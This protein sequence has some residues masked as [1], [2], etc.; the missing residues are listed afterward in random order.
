MERAFYRG[1]SHFFHC[2]FEGA[3]V[4]VGIFIHTRPKRQFARKPL[5]ELDG[6]Y[7]GS[8]VWQYFVKKHTRFQEI[9]GKKAL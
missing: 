3:Y 5:R 7:H 8:V 9:I 2:H 1:D 6:V 4:C